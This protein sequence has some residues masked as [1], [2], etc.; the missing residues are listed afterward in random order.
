ML[1]KVPK[2]IHRVPSLSIYCIIPSIE[3]DPIVIKCLPRTTI[4]FK[5]ILGKKHTGRLLELV[6]MK[7]TFE[8]G[9]GVVAK[10]SALPMLCALMLF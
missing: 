5:R 1:A 10:T 7:V 9:K 2:S 6:I 4:R 8:T 3:S